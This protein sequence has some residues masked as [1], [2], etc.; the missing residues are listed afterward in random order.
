MHSFT[1]PLG[2]HVKT[3]TSTKAHKPRTF[4]DAFHNLQDSSS[5]HDAEKSIMQQPKALPKIYKKTHYLIQLASLCCIS[6]D[7]H[8]DFIQAADGMR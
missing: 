2:F 3:K 5:L 1:Y 8:P 4:I 6:C 7:P